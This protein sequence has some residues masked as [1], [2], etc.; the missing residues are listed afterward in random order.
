MSEFQKIEDLSI[1]TLREE[2][3]M[4]RTDAA[5]RLATLAVEVDS[6]NPHSRVGM[7]ARREFRGEA[8]TLNDALAG[9]YHPRCFCCGFSIRPGDAVI[10]DVSEGEM[11]ADCPS[12]EGGVQVLRPGDKVFMEPDS[13][14]IDEDHPD[15][16]EAGDK[17]DHIVAHESARLYTH[18]QIV[19]KALSALEMARGVSSKSS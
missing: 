7:N 1:E 6:T 16:G 2:V 10:Q 8:E 15:G 9:R 4:W 12:E 17:P 18:E 14:V 5:A 3:W 19:A 13:I 11:H